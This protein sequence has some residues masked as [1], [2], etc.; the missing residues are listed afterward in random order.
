MKKYVCKKLR[1]NA[2]GKVLFF[3]IDGTLVGFDG[4]IPESA[5][6]A[7]A[8]ASAAGH[9]IVICSGRAQFQVH[10]E[11]KAIADGLVCCTGAT[12]IKGGRVLSEHFMTHD[13]MVRIIEV[14]KETGAK[15]AG[16]TDT[17]MVLDQACYDSMAERFSKRAMS[18][19]AKEQAIEQ[20]LGGSIITDHMEDHTD[21]KKM[22]YY[23]A[24]RDVDLVTL[25]LKEVCDV[26]PASFDDGPRDCGEISSLG[27]NKSYGMMKYMESQGLS[28]EDAIAFGDG[29]NDMDMI[30]YAGV[31]VAMG[32]A[33]Q[34]LKDIAD[35][36]TKDVDKDGVA[37][38]MKELGLI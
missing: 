31:G 36:V 22:L 34:E 26:V 24:D 5:R 30:E 12:S 21:I 9:Q 1:K 27:I 37:F 15:Y 11:F 17:A 33:I 20:I 38:A 16:M 32:N 13:E 10:E 35:F 7:L 19:E 29:P 6:A 23:E 14:L 2:M 3:D 25:A 18:Q 28:R 8:A 4:K